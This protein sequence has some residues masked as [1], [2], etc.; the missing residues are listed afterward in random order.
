VRDRELPAR[1]AE[2]ILRRGL[3]GLSPLAESLLAAVLG[4]GLGAIIMALSGF[5]PIV[6]YAALLKGGFASTYALATTAA[7]AAPLL[8]T[9][10]TFAICS[11][12][13]MFNIGAEG[14]VYMG[15]LATVTLSYFVLPPGVGQI[16]GIL[17]AMTAGA[18]WSLVPALLRVFRGVNEVI[19]TIMFNWISHFLALYLVAR[20]L[21]DP[22]R[23]SQ[24]V[25]VPVGA[26]FPILIRGTDLSYAVFAAL[27]FAVAIYILLWHT[28]LGYEI[29]AAG[30]N[31]RAAK[32]GGIK[33]KRTM[34]ASFLLGGMSAGL[35]GAAMTMGTPPSYAVFAGLSQIAGLGF[36]GMAVAVV[37][38]NHPLGMIASAFF[39]GGLAA[40]AREMQMTAGVPTEMVSVV[41]GVIV[42]AL[43]VPELARVFRV[44][45]GRW[46][47][48]LGRRG[49]A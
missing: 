25:R 45:R 41:Q 17:F 7:C 9:G 32:Y 22:A 11:R 12:A 14:Q 1:G 30:F 26:R 4:L 21:V 23:S 29:R 27:A 36:N 44:F 6:A 28:A 46:P 47:R 5:N 10:L 42:L 20:V 8:L 34:V 49:D 2:G 35:A 19:S 3:F 39:F 16:V 13:G 40:G 43:A 31:P 33:S 38:R 18:L 24:T 37:G 48:L 15:A